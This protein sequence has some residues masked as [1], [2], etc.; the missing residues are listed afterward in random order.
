MNRIPQDELSEFLR[1]LADALDIPDSYYEKAVKR[2]K[3]L[4]EW[5]D[6]DDCT[7]EE[8]SDVYPQGSF[9]MGTVVRPL[10]ESDEYDLDLIAEFDAPKSRWTQRELKNKLGAELRAYAYAHGIKAPVVEKQRCW[11]LD[12]ADGVKFHMDVVPAVP[13]HTSFKEHLKRLGVPPGLAETTNVITDNTHRNYDRYDLDWPKS[14][15]RG[16][17]EWFKERMK[18]RFAEQQREIMLKEARAK[19]EDVPDYRVKTPLQRAV[20]FLK[21]HR[22]YW[23]KGEKDHRPISVIITTL[24]AW[25]YNNEVDLYEALVNIVRDMPEHITKRG[26]VSWV[27]NPVNPEENFA[28]KWEHHPEREQAFHRWMQQVQRDVHLLTQLDSFDEIAEYMEKRAGARPVT[29]AINLMEKKASAVRTLAVR[30]PQL[31]SL[32]NV[33]HRKKPKWRYALNGHRAAISAQLERN[34]YRPRVL[35]NNEEGVP[36]NCTLRFFVQTSVPWPFQVYWQVVNT[37]KD[38]IF[39]GD[40]RGGFYHEGEPHRAGKT[41]VESTKYT[42]AHWIQCFIVKNG[43]CVAESQEFIVNIR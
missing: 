23:F 19:V 10:S 36:K 38:A 7:F 8:D 14:N 30:Q 1:R 5:L 26:D 42:G 21:R 6:R 29:E 25:S 12:Y 13:D 3:S 39:A 18:V 22:D 27:A 28:D 16:Y 31:P 24:A 2:Y 15:P 32:F 37:G 4:G 9:R 17:A 20:Q 41:W 33:P 40:E 11:R 34:G 35:Q 43:V